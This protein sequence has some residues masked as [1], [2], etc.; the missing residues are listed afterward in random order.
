MDHLQVPLD[1]LAARVGRFVADENARLL[2]VPVD[3]TLTDAT[4]APSCR[5]STAP[6]VPVTTTSCSETAL[7]VISKSTV[8]V[9][10]AVMD[11]GF[12]SVR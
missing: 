7:I 3:A 6:A 12:C 2:W 5:R 1:E 4:V 8:A 9:P 10:L 11:T